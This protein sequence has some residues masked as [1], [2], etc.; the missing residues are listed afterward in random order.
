MATAFGKV[1]RGTLTSDSGREARLMA[2][3]CMSGATEIG[4][5]ANGG[6]VC[7]M[8]MGATSSQTA[9]STLV[10]ISMA[11][12]TGSDNTPGRTGIHTQENL[13]TA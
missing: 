12:Q 10:N 5:R 11:I 7:D 13:L 1:Q 8:A 4:M 2:T 9:M 3:E 6:L